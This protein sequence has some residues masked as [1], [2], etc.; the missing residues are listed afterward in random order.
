V[1]RLKE[2]ARKEGL[3]SINSAAMDMVREGLT[4]IE[5]VNRVTTM[6]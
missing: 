1:R 4:T 3:K 5:E 2:L 6:A